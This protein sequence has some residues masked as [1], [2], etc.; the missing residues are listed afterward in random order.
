MSAPAGTSSRNVVSRVWSSHKN[1][2]W[3][4]KKPVDLKPSPYLRT[5]VSKS[6]P[7]GEITGAT[8]YGD[9]RRYSGVFPGDYPSHWALPSYMDQLR[10]EAILDALS[11]L[12]DQKFNAGVALA[13]AK[14]TAQLA[15]DV[16]NWISSLRRGLREDPRKVYDRFRRR[17]GFE[18]WQSFKDRYGQSLNR[19]E[20]LSAVPRGW[21]YYHFGIK[22]TMQDL[23]DVHQDWFRRHSGAL[24]GF[25]S[26]VYGK[27]AYSEQREE[28][29]RFD[30]FDSARMRYRERQ[31][32]RVRLEVVPRNSFLVKLA[33]MGGSNIPE[34][35]WNGV[36]YSWVVDYFTS[37]GQWLHALDA[38]SGYDYGDY[39]ESYR[40]V[41]EADCK[42]FIN[43]SIPSAPKGAMHLSRPYRYRKKVVDR[44][45]PVLTY[46][47]VYRTLP[48]VK[49]K[50]PGLT[51]FANMLS[52][53]SSL[54]A[55]RPST[56][57]RY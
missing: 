13:E 15:T 44:R 35:L 54:F 40:L 1:G 49:L 37:M 29:V 42:S 39:S 28:D 57:G 53:L 5:I 16:G 10:N 17:S 11:N 26:I 45:V 23:D 51:Q 43:K 21:T 9:I 4:R 56:I 32:M 22:P 50:G 8:V 55:G 12:K 14:G 46:P 18:S 41:A 3:D 2:N 33:Q 27:A 52:V 30:I 48:Q 47:P 36:P 34:A 31:S 38:M 20:R 7:V 25:K 6:N 24:E 19:A